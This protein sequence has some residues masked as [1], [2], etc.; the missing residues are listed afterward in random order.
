MVQ[1]L[2]QRHTGIY[3]FT[4]KPADGEAGNKWDDNFLLASRTMQ[5]VFNVKH[6]GA[7]Q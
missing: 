5:T 4:N 3:T 7:E 2:E 6:Y 1:A